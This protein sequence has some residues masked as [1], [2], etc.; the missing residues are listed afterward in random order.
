MIP[1]DRVSL[2]NSTAGKSRG[3][4]TMD[5]LLGLL[6]GF[7]MGLVTVF[8]MASL[9]FVGGWALLQFIDTDAAASEP[10]PEETNIHMRERHIYEM[11]DGRIL[12]IRDAYL[13]EQ[14]RRVVK[15][16]T[17]KQR[18]IQER[19]SGVPCFSCGKRSE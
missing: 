3:G 15:P 6:F 18:E 4:G 5:K 9:L 17:R 16:Y 19:E 13:G 7:I 14:D 11:E 12:I 2:A 1:I 10:E 8:A